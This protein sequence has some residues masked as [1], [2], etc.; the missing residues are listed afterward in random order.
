MVKRD[1]REIDGTF[2]KIASI[3]MLTHVG[4][5]N[6]RSFM[7]IMRRA[8]RPGGAMIVECVGGNVTKSHCDPW[9][10]RYIFPGGV[11]PSL[12]QVGPAIEGIFVLEDLHNF[13]PDYART[14][15][16]WN[17]NLHAGWPALSARYPERVLRMF[18]YFFLSVAATF[19]VRQLQQ[20]QF[21]LTPT[22]APP[23]PA[24]RS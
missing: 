18:R 13:G 19:A 17:E 16:A 24:M 9:V 11:I 23:P 5:R 4:P 8:L 6:Y 14:L 7:Q 20:W 2:D 21:V 3:A 22:G 10:D 12:G 15:R 1:Y